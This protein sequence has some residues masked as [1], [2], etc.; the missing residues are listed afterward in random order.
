MN[1]RVPRPFSF[2]SPKNYSRCFE[3][4]GRKRRSSSVLERSGK[5]DEERRCATVVENA[6]SF[7][8]LLSLAERGAKLDA[9]HGPEN[10]RPLSRSATPDTTR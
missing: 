8:L 2:V 1:A 10:S 3:K 9:V 6:L 7:L 4:K 5:R